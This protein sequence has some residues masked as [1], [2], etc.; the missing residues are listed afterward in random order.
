[1]EFKEATRRYWP[2]LILLMIGVWIGAGALTNLDPQVIALALGCVVI[3]TTLAQIF[4]PNATFL[5]RHARV[6]NPVAGGLIGLC[7]G[8]TG[9]FTPVIVYFAA[10]RLPKNL[11][12]AQMAM[13]AMVGSVPLYLRLITEGHMSWPQFT[14]SALAMIPVGIG[15]ATGFWIRK[16]ISEAFFRR[17][18]QVGLILLGLM[19]IWRGLS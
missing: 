14:A 12:V 7:S 6:A 5:Q 18:V 11:F 9:A 17:L 3:A 10:L 2:F 13:A 4:T 15:I 19:L 8:A 16:R 1:G